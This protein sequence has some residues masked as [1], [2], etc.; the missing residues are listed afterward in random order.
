MA[1][2]RDPYAGDLFSA[3]VKRKSP[4]PAPPKP[5]HVASDPSTTKY[6]LTLGGAAVRL[7]LSRAE[8]RAMIEHGQVE[9][10]PMGLTRAIPTRE[11]TRILG[12]Q[13]ERSTAQRSSPPTNDELERLV[14]PRDTDHDRHRYLPRKAADEIAAARREIQSALE[15]LTRYDDG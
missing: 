13:D 11:I 4:P 8:L 6:V 10:V 5:A 7:G 12:R 9:V 1:Q 14:N 15:E 2:G 3:P